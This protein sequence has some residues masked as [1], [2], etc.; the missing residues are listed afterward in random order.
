MVIH[1]HYSFNKMSKTIGFRVTEFE[2]QKIK[3]ALS[4]HQQN[5]LKDLVFMLLNSVNSNVAESKPEINENSICV[6]FP[7]SKDKIHFEAL[8]KLNKVSKFEFLKL[9][10]ENAKGSFFSTLKIK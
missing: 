4:T 6:E 3:D 2:E 1:L 7:T 10:I 9:L 8:I 5:N